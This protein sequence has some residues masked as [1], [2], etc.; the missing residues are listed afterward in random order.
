M[1]TSLKG[2]VLEKPR[3]GSS[4]SPFTASPDNVIS[5]SGAYNA[6]FGVDESTPGRC[7]YLILGLVDGD[8]PDVEFG[9]TKNEG[10]VNRF[11]YDSSSDTFKPLPGSTRQL[12]GVL[13]VGANTTRL[14]VSVPSASIIVAPFRISVGSIGSGTTFTVILVPN[15]LSFTTPLPGEVQLSQTTGNLNWNPSDITTNYVGQEVFYQQQSGFSRQQSTGLLGTTSDALLLNPIP[16]TGQKPL[17]RFGF[18]LHLASVQVASEGAFSVNPI[19]GT[20]EWALTTGRLKFNTTDLAQNA[21]ESV[22]YDGVLFEVGKTLPRQAIGTVSSPTTISSLPAVGGDLVFRAKK[23]GLTGTATFLTTDTLQNMSGNFVTNKVKKGDIVILTSG[24]YSG[25]RRPIVSVSAT[26]LVVSPPFPSVSGATYTI[27]K[28]ADIAQF[29]EDTRVVALSSPGKT[30]VVQVDGTG[31]VRFSTSDQGTYGSR[32]AEVVIGDL[33]L[34]RG[35]SV[36]VYRSQVDLSAKDP[37]VKD[38]STFFVVTDSTLADPIIGAPFVSLPVLPIDEAA[39]PT[40]ISVEQGTGSF[41]GILPRLDVPSPP[42]GIGYTLDFEGRQLVYATRRN[43]QVS[44]ISSKTAAFQLP[45]PLINP[46]NTVLELNQGLGYVPLTLGV[47]AFL[48][49]TSGVVSFVDTKGAVVVEGSTGEVSALDTLEDSTADFVAAGVIA[50]DLVVVPTGPLQGVYTVLTVSTTEL[51]VTPSF[52]APATGVQY[53]VRRG[54]E[55]LADRFFQEVITVDPSTKVEKVRGLGAISNSPRLTVDVSLVGST[56]IRLASGSIVTLTQV[57]NDGAFTA[58]GS[59]SSGSVEVSLT[60]GNLNFSQADVTAGGS[61][62]YVLK[63]TQGVDYRMN[64]DL[65]FIQFSERMLAFDEVLV[66][67]ASTSDPSTYT[68]ERSAFLVRKEVLDHPLVTATLSFNPTGRTVA[69]SPAPAVFR[70]G[71]PQTTSQVSV[72]VV[73]SQLTFLPDV[74]PTPGG[75]LVVT[76]ATPHGPIIQPE[77][78]IYVDYYVREALGGENTITVLNPPISLAKVLINEGDTTFTLKGDWTASFPA[79]SLLRFGSD[80]VYYI[81][82]VGYDGELTTIT[83]SQPFRESLQDPK[84]YVSSGEIRLTA[85]VDNP[86]YFILESASFVPVPRGMNKIK[87]QGDKASLYQAGVVVYFSGGGPNEFYLVSGSMYDLDSDK[88]EITLTQPS[89]RQYVSPTNSLR[90]SVRPVFEEATTSVRTSDT[91]LIAPPAMSIP[92]SVLVFRQVEG[93]PGVILTSPEDYKIDESGKITLTL[94]LGPGEEVSI[95]YTKYRFV[96]PGQLRAS[97]T[98]TVVPSASNGLAG[99]KLMASLTT[100]LPD[101]IYFRIETMTTFRSEVSEEYKAEAKASAPSGGPRT[102]NASQ[103]DLHE[104]G[105]ASAYFTEGD[106]KNE[107]IIARSTLKY[108]ND[109]VNYL[110]DLLRN[111]DGRVVGDRDGKL[112]FDG[113][114]GTVVATFDAALNQID[115]LFK[116]SNFP[117]DPTPPLFPIKYIGTYL[118]AY[119]ASSNSRFYT[120]F[121]NKFGYTVSGSD[122]SAKTGDTIL[123]FETKNL[124]GVSPATER[125]TPRALL[126]RSSKAGETVIYVDTTAQVDTAPYRPPFANGMKVVIQDPSGSFYVP[127]GAPLTISGVSSTSIT[128]GA[129]LPVNV[130]IGATVYLADSDTVYRKSYR[131]GF[132]VTFD[133][134]KGFLLYVKPYPPFDGSAGGVPA[135]LRIQTPESEEL[136]EAGLTLSNRL[137][138]PERIPVLDGKPLDDDGDQRLPLIN[139]TPAREVG[140]P[141]YLETELTFIGPS[142]LLSTNTVPPFTGTGDLN[143]AGTTITLTSGTFPSPV[144]QTGDLVR[145]LSGVNGASSFRRITSATASSITVDVAFTTDTNFTFLVTVASNLASG[146]FTTMA[147][148]VV[149]DTLANFVTAGVKP[150]HTVVLTQIGN[151]SQYQRRQVLSVAATQLTLTAAFTTLTVPA[152]YRVHNPLNTYSEIGD[153]TSEAGALSAILVGNA[154]S[155]VNSIDAFFTSVLTDRLSP[156]TASG[157]TSGTTITGISVDFIA[158]GV[159]PGDLVYLPPVQTSQGFYLVEEVT[160]P[161]TITVTT[162]F[163]SSGAVSF[164]VVDTEVSDVSLN[165]LL[166]IRTDTVLF[167]STVAA[168][169]SLVSTPVS[170]LVPPGV[171]D[172]TYFARGYTPADFSSRTSTVNTRKAFVTT[173]VPKVEAVLSST[174]RLYDKR[175]VWIDA[176]INLEKGILVKQQRAVADRIK[177]QAETLKQLTKLLAVG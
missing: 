106:L 98:A 60:T 142:G 11:D 90:R 153:L 107:D 152:T 146:T 151:P 149:T 127:Q 79:N 115:D 52:S 3:V 140:T 145:T 141:G 66:T 36:R 123:D 159:Q 30:G 15:D 32:S 25:R 134:E 14:K 164:R 104:K 69:P 72:N 23:P 77:E 124:T 31:A 172:A 105:S 68:T 96:E 168:W 158:S 33:P 167:N 129:G 111:L 116:I 165:D 175:Y 49:A 8:L 80:Q 135:E 6:V 132:D 41:T 56:R 27:E 39:Y 48:D 113:T 4:N 83:V 40:V 157:N 128:F 64:P 148:P 22:Y 65:G 10:G 150:G 95:L 5:D 154:D 161:T 34:E 170:V 136:L 35:L 143:G 71:R 130:P 26:Q 139:P 7:E 89:V 58:P 44:T 9:W 92:D 126:T 93:S 169:S 131:N 74:I 121:R 177:A 119:E 162:P 114:T 91:P 82:S 163:P 55:I 125:R 137:T 47:D 110:E 59:M 17:V 21:G 133:M 76:D 57:V 45:D 1:A 78:R 28:K 138:A 42:S 85:T 176:R 84:V 12:V 75:A 61:V 18:G 54:K 112:K 160:G 16:G 86:A 67:Y 102:E 166:G 97:Y 13:S 20:V 81:V 174:D 155:E 62:S 171:A 156:V 103:P 50:Q 99:Q 19:Q 43:A 122:T 24:T 63:L 37:S 94:P 51:T 117:I 100:Y 147:G 70:G 120:T 29:P 46:V 109:T 173:S 38:I 108:Y 88:T 101:S 144:P 87:V 73:G 2:Y 118:R 53:Q